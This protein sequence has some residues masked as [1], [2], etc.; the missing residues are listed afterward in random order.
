MGLGV[1]G[2]Y[3]DV[4]SDIVRCGRFLTIFGECNDDLGLPDF[5]L[6]QYWNNIKL[7]P[8]KSV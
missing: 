6:Y 5:I 7:S 4:S 1:G 8:K 3:Q 2:E